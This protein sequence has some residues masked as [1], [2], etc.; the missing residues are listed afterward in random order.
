MQIIFE[1][2]PQ[3]VLEQIKEYIIRSG[4]EFSVL[5]DEAPKTEERIRIIMP[6]IPEV[7][8]VEMPPKDQKPEPVAT[9]PE[10]PLQ[11]HQKCI[12]CA[13]YFKHVKMHVLKCR[14]NPNRPS[15]YLPEE[16][17]RIIN[18]YKNSRYGLTRK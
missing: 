18:Q 8:I 15:A 10:S 4:Y 2:T 7:Q 16:K 5:D 17:A 1:G 12:H 13:N 9:E 6:E 14:R 3:E 11:G